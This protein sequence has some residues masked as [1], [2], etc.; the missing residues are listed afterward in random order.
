[1]TRGISHYLAILL[2]L[3]VAGGVAFWAWNGLKSPPVSEPT[4][5]IVTTPAGWKGFD[6]GPFSLYAPKYAVLRKLQ[7]PGAAVG[8]LV[9]LGFNLR[10]EFGQR[11]STLVDQGNN[12]DYS[13]G[14]MVIDGRRGL[15]RKATLSAETQQARFGAYAQPSYIGVFI[16]QAIRHTTPDGKDQWYSLQVEGVAAN[17]DQRDM[18]EMILKS[19]RFNGMR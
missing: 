17:A 13:E 12:T 18:V 15:L 3:A 4:V 10:Y 14:E 9:G 5:S 11:S 6:A 16:P 1:M 2:T 7:D 19:V 8:M